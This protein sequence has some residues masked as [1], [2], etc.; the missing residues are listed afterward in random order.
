MTGIPL[1]QVIGTKYRT[2]C[3]KSR[4]VRW[5]R[6]LKR[7][8]FDGSS[9]QPLA[10]LVEAEDGRKFKLLRAAEM[11]RF[12]IDLMLHG[13]LAAS[14]LD[15]VPRI[16]W[17]DPHNILL[18]YIEG[19]TP[20]V[21]SVRFAKAFGRC[22]ARMHH[23]DADYLCAQAISYSVERDIEDMLTGRVLGG[24]E[25]SRLRERIDRLLPRA[26]R[27]SLLYADLQVSN[28]CFAGDGRL[29]CF[30]LGG[31]VRGRLTDEF[32]FGHSLSRQLNLEVFKESYISA[33]GM[34]D[35]FEMADLLRVL[36]DIRMAAFLTR[37]AQKV[38]FL[39]PRRRRAFYL[40]RDELLTRLRSQL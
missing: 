3:L 30:D 12:R 27:T 38:T 34:P 8:R 33:G 15:F 10:W 39:E 13:Y 5:N 25:A 18:E 22:L 26:M 2:R 4:S 7:L 24:G 28:F 19:E 35:L 29:I 40:R 17:N 11:N 20:D 37:L 36:N 31:F 6:V 32:F 14:K 16:V 1:E 21:T 23:I 9:L